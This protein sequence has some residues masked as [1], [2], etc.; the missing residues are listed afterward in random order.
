MQERTEYI[1]VTIGKILGRTGHFDCTVDVPKCR[2][3]RPER[4]LFLH[5]RAR[6]HGRPLC[7]ALPRD[8]IK[9]KNVNMQNE[10]LHL[11]D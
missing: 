5:R 6:G 2:L 10:R 1:P 11:W 4:R 9:R 3:S 7:F 8:P